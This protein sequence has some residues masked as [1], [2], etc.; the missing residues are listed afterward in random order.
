M[1]NRFDISIVIPTHNRAELLLE[2]LAS[3]L[4][5][6]RYRAEIIVVDDASTDDTAELLQTRL[7]VPSRHKLILLHNS[8]NAGAQVCRN[9]GLERASAPVVQFVDSDDV[10]FACGVEQGLD[11]LKRSSNF[12]FV[13]G[14][15]SKCDSTLQPL[16]NSVT[17]T[18]YDDTPSHIAGYHWHTMGA[19]YRAE[20]LRL[21]VGRWN[22]DLSGSQ[23]WEF[24]ARVKLASPRRK[25]VPAIF[26]LWRQHD[27]TRVS[28]TSYNPKYVES[29]SLAVQSIAA[30]A[31]KYGVVDRALM[32]RLWRR[33][34]LHA[35]E[36]GAYG[37]L[38]QKQALIREANNLPFEYSWGRSLM[39]TA[40]RRAPSPFNALI[41]RHA[42]RLRKLHRSP[43]RTRQGNH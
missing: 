42:P 17:G 23:D 22:E 38:R 3:V 34:V 40:I 29:V 31:L 33:L 2:C 39:E 1:D 4:P 7:D 41:F 30:N 43:T 24:Q 15:V 19:L 28:V 36:A 8:E 32:W 10:L 9:K 27:A 5:I 6:E 13:Y 20:F 18:V 21:S 26:G 35:I 11:A 14:Q 37:D 12:D 16:C 25:F